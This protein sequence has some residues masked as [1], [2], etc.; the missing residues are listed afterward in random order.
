MPDLIPG[1]FEKEGP[2]VQL[3]VFTLGYEGRELADVLG[4]VRAHG[5]EEVLD[6]R[7]NASSRKKGFDAAS[8]MERLSAMGVR[9][10]H[11]AE[12]GCE[13]AS[14]HDLWNGGSPDA[15]FDAYRRRLA[16]HPKAVEELVR[17]ARASRCLLLC[18]E[19]E[20]SRCHRRVLGEVLREHGFL[21]RDL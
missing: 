14:R 10:V 2:S 3:Q 9:Y 7:E 13:R 19:R 16:E 6:V 20:V 5:I 12:L 18:L 4:A 8:L 17:W 11:S 21:V 15:F 1:A